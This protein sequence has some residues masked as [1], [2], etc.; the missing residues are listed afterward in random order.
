M[1]AAAPEVKVLAY[2]HA[3]ANTEPDG[4][5]KYTDSHL[6]NDKG[7]HIG[8]PFEYRVPLYLPTRENSYGKALWKYVHT[9]LD[10]MKVDGLY[11]DEM[12][13]SVL[14]YSHS[15]SWDNRTVIID[16]QT[17]AVVGKRTSVPLAMQPLQLEISKYLRDNGKYLMA[18]GQPMTRTLLQEK[19]VRFVECQSYQRLLDTHFASPIGLGNHFM[20]KNQADTARHIREMLG[21]GALY[22]ADTIYQ[23]KPPTWPFLSVM[24]PITPVELREGMVLGAER[25]QT[26]KSGRFGWP[27]GAAADVYVIDVAG[28]RVANPQVK[29][30][31]ENGR[32]LYDIR[33]PSDQFAVLVKK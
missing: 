31:V 7:E 18:N 1:H 2:F 29:E 19:I 11:W 24:F 13:Y 17:H 4:E 12:T 33:I 5:T 26:A 28:N 3:Q 23:E 6:L 8:Y 25:I 9:A 22:Y 27:D 10:E 21:Y 14:E 30:V 16:P 20:E 15:P 32:R